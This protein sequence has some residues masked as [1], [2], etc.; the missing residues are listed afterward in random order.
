M[1]EARGPDHATATSKQICGE[2]INSKPGCGLT[3]IPTTASVLKKHFTL[4]QLLW[5]TPCVRGRQPYCEGGVGET[6]PWDLTELL[7]WERM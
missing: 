5:S 2:G 1:R 3:P 7:P 4:L 6:M